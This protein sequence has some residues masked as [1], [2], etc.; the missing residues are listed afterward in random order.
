[1]TGMKCYRVI[2]SFSILFLSCLWEGCSPSPAGSSSSDVNLDSLLRQAIKTTEQLK[3]EEANESL[4]Y[5]VNQARERGDEKN[6]I[7]GTINLGVLY[8]KYSA[9]DE[10]LKHFLQSLELAETYQ[11]EEFLN[12]IYNNIGV[13][14]STNHGVDQAIE[15]YKKALA[16][17]RKQKNQHR[18]ALNLINLGTEVHKK[19]NTTEAMGHL[20][21]ALSI[22]FANRDTVNAS[23]AL[24]NIADIN[25]GRN[26]KYD[27]A[28]LQYRQAYAMS[29]RMKDR[30]Y[31]P[32]YCLSLGK[33]YFQLRHYDSAVFFL[34]KG[35]EGFREMKNTENIIECYRWLSRVNDARGDTGK[36]F[37]YSKT[38]LA[39]KDSL[40]AEKASKWISELQMRY[41]YGKKEKEIEFL[42]QEA[43]RQRKFWIGVILVSIIIALLIFLALRV[44]YI[45][46]QQRNIIL[47]K[48]QE[49]DRLTLEK[50]KAEQAR[51]KQDLTFKDRE[52]ATKALH[53]VNK[54]EIFASV[55]KVLTAIDL[56]DN[57]SAKAHLDKA[58]KIIR[59]N[60]SID[61]EW[62]AFKLHFDEVHPQFFSRLRETYPDLS[63][64]DLRLSAYLLIDLN[65]KEI[66]QIFN[67]S[68]ESIR[69]KK[70][71]LR[72][73]LNLE[74]EED[75]KILLNRFKATEK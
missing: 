14:Y 39:W 41:E 47:Q 71:R 16:I 26:Q 8:L 22:F 43:N 59:G 55:H 23:V 11:R 13:I 61:Q 24:N 65:S 51:L 38:T 60:D 35:V 37:E 66:A 9:Y 12:T 73:K 34:E 53:L 48:E 2:V 74:K 42:Q 56:R 31:R 44:K 29:V 20:K 6:Q 46:L 45:N 28:L 18:I 7:L 67:I 63:A 54:N 5:I 3:F 52:L 36:A 69:K 25:Y 15:Y 33:T 19:G 4:N 30:Y 70:Q 50:N 57:P 40:L 49:V 62:E 72:Q 1:M 68:P 17:S 64:N 75:I 32:Q 21:E 27:S 58:K 10:A